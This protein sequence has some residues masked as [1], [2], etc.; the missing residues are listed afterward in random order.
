MRTTIGLRVQAA[1]S[2]N[3]ATCTGPEARAGEAG[4][5]ICHP[6]RQGRRSDGGRT[7]DVHRFQASPMQNSRFA[8][9]CGEQI[10]DR[11]RKY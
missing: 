5:R 4:D 2:G 9:G 3:A 6:D 8:A 11:N 7:H 1:R 10:D